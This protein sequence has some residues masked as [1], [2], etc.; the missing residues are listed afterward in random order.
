MVFLARKLCNPQAKIERRGNL[1]RFERD[2]QGRLVGRVYADGSREGYGYDAAGRLSTRIDALGQ[3]TDYRHAR[4]DRLAGMDYAGALEETAPV[5]F[6]DDPSY[7]RR[8]RM[9]DGSGETRYGYHPAGGPGGLQLA[10]EDGPSEDDTIGYGYDAL[11][12]LGRRQVGAAEE[13][14]SYDALGR[15]GAHRNPLGVF[16]YTYLGDSG[17]V[18]GELLEGVPVAQWRYLDN[19]GDRRL[20][21]MAYPGGA[22]A[23]ALRSDAYRILGI[24]EGD[25]VRLYRYDAK[26]RLVLAADVSRAQES[27]RLDRVRA[28]RGVLYR[29]DAADN[30]LQGRTLPR[31]I[32]ALNQLQRW[33]GEDL[34]YDANGNLVADG[35]WRYR[36][37]AENRLVAMQAQDGGELEYRFGYDGLGRRVS[38]SG[39]DSLR[40][41][42]WCAETICRLRSSGGSLT[43]PYPQGEWRGGRR[44][45]EERD[46]LGGVRAVRDLDRGG[47][48]GQF[49]YAPY[50][51]LRQ[52]SGTALPERGHAGMFRHA[53]SGLY[54]THFRAYSPVHGRWL[55]RDPIHELGGVNLYA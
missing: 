6:E 16:G 36:Y 37:D 22:G 15:I 7:P 43:Y 40:N 17:Q 30:L 55:S 52:R 23:R 48:L 25:W 28:T 18:T 51:E 1:T 5:R 19:A 29:Y 2:I 41:L 26:D 32:N 53:D 42:R 45:Y 21:G 44:L 24:A 50:G 47:I 3:R 20:A 27:G 34:A 8:V 12:R 14:W 33:A 11:G 54:L 38:E 49:D 35:R 46:H 31:Q 9:I 39:N 10:V 4:D 13:R